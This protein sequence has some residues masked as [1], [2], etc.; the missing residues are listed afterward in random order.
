M[1]RAEDG[2][3]LCVGEGVRV[4]DLVE[5]GGGVVCDEDGELGGQVAGVRETNVVGGEIGKSSEY[6]SGH[7]ENQLRQGNDISKERREKGKGDT[8]NE[9]K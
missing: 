9:N 1:D 5:E 7:F 3:E 4:L 6:V 2:D 8:G